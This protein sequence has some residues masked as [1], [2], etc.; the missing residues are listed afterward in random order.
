M[1]VPVTTRSL[2]DLYLSQGYGKE[3]RDAYAFLL[4]RSPG[5][6][7][8]KCGLDKA[9]ALVNASKKAEVGVLLEEWV[10]LVRH[11]KGGGTE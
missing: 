7:G 11:G 10:A 9:Q 5:D 2:A 1:S 8:L 4:D 6:E 3:A